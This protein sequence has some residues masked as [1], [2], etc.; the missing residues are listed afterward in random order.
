MKK[1]L[2]LVVITVFII[3][4]AGCAS[5]P[6]TE[7]PSTVSEPVKQVNPATI[8]FGPFWTGTVRLDKES[9][10]DL[11]DK[12]RVQFKSEW[13]LGESAGIV[14][15]KSFTS[16]STGESVEMDFLW[17]I[18]GDIQGGIYDAVVDID[19]LPGTGTIK[20]L[21]LDKGTAYNVYISFKAAKI[22]I[23]LETDGDDI[24]VYPE[25]TYDKYENLGRLDNIPEELLINHVSSYTERNQIY[26]LIPAGVPLDI[27]RTFSK[28]DAKWLK[29]Y[30]AAPESFIKQFN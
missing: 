8:D 26:W 21:K 11:A 22:D 10:P 12:A 17:D 24:F 16:S 25:G 6:Q 2:L 19:G 18:G 5:A 1:Y 4:F 30:S 28:G 27:L 15:P 3:L 20:N 29:G 23:P 14:Y 9:D 7:A 13:T